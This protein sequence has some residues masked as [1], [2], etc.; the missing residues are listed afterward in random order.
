MFFV[1]PCASLDLSLLFLDFFAFLIYYSSSDG[2]DS[3]SS[4]LSLSSYFI[5]VGNS[6]NIL[7]MLPTLQGTYLNM[8]VPCSILKLLY[9][10]LY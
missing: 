4:S 10:D 8:K 7:R 9:F 2:D 3:N 1:L 5:I 6:A